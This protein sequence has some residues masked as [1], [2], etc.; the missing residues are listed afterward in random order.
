[1]VMLQ[2]DDATHSC[3][4]NY[5]ACAAAHSRDILQIL[6]I[7]IQMPAATFLQNTNYGTATLAATCTAVLLQQPARAAPFEVRNDK[8]QS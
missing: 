7:S 6:H 5:A 2:A 1:M 4:L 8:D 3:W